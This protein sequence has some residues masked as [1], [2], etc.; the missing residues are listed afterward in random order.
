[1]NLDHLSRALDQI[2][3]LVAGVRS[4]QADEPTPCAAWLSPLR[5]ETASHST[6]LG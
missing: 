3:A 4:D 5:N 2:G 6:D 1:M